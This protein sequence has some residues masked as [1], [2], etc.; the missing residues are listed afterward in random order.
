MNWQLH[1]LMVNVIGMW[2]LITFGSAP[3]SAYL[4]GSNWWIILMGASLRYL[5]RS[6]HTVSS[7]T[8]ASLAVVSG[9]NVFI[10]C[11]LSVLDRGV[12]IYRSYS[13]WV[14]KQVCILIKVSNSTVVVYIP[15][16]YV[17]KLLNIQIVHQV[18][19]LSDTTWN[20]VTVTNAQIL[21]FNF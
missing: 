3:A 9:D 4:A 5:W 6:L 11:V 1:F 17:L 10:H 2:C 15:A 13:A 7:I 20:T 19:K 16:I 8:Q 21:Q 18:P 12:C 14:F